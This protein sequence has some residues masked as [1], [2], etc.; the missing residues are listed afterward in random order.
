MQK[1]IKRENDKVKKQKILV[2]HIFGIFKRVFNQGY[3]FIR[4]KQMVTGE[5]SLTVFVYNIKRVLKIVGLER[6]KEAIYM[7]GNTKKMIVNY[8]RETILCIC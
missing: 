3:M 7:I 5:I 4:G 2:E 6:L 1:R 8:T